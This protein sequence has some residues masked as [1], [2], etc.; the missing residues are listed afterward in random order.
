MGHSLPPFANAGVR[1]A[2]EELERVCGEVEKKRASKRVIE[3]RASHVEDFYTRVCEEI[4]SVR[5]AVCLLRRVY[6]A[7]SV[8]SHDLR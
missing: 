6:Q 4:M 3:S 7:H 8:G 1:K 5:G 2:F